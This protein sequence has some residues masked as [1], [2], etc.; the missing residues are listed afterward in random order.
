M[1][2]GLDWGEY[3]VSFIPEKY[4]S[5]CVCVRLCVYLT[6]ARTYTQVYLKFLSQTQTEAFSSLTETMRKM[7]VRLFQKQNV[8]LHENKR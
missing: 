3:F 1:R 6:C 5:V 4:I 7:F 8:S 2:E